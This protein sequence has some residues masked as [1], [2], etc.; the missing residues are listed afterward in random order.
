MTTAKKNVQFLETVYNWRVPRGLV[1][2]LVG[3]AAV[4]RLAAENDPN[5]QRE[6]LRANMERAMAIFEGDGFRD[7]IYNLLHVVLLNKNPRTLVR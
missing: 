5:P 6:V 7:V 2:F 1:D 4:L 3:Q